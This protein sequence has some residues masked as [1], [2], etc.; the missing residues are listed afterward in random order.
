MSEKHLFACYEPTLSRA[1]STQKN[2]PSFT[3][4]SRDLSHRL[5]RVLRLKPGEQFILF[6]EVHWAQLTLLK[7]HKNEVQVTLECCEKLQSFVPRITLALGL[8]KR[9]ALN[10]AVYSATQMGVDTIVPL[11]TEKVSRSWGG[12]KEVF[13]LI[14]WR[15]ILNPPQPL[16]T[17]SRENH[18]RFYQLP[19]DQQEESSCRQNDRF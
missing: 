13:R 5:T 3:I 1:Y 7:E 6:D 9:D 16:Y 10:E 11:L 18:G 12:E 4:K 14:S 2:D 19:P 8:L 17:F 15:P